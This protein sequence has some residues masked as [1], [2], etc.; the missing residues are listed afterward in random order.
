[1]PRT[2]TDGAVVAGWGASA[3]GSE[4]I[5]WIESDGMR[6]LQQVLIDDHGLDLGGFT[7][8]LDATGISDDGLTIVGTGINTS[9]F[10][11]AF[12]A[13]I[14]LQGKQV[15]GPTKETSRAASM[16]NPQRLR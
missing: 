4:A 13:T 6:T 14:E 1:M 7:R 10:A 3:I 16:M 9:G 2:L 11:E 8:L 5:L 15:A 12:M